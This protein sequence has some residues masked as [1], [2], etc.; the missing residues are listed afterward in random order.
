MTLNL[1]LDR[2][3]RTDRTCDEV[4]HGRSRRLSHGDLPGAKLLLDQ[5]VING[6]LLELAAPLPVATA[7]ADVAQPE[8]WWIGDAGVDVIGRR[9]AASARLAIFPVDHRRMQH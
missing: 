6:E 2:G 4:A 8:R 5:R 3:L 7:V 9:A 1:G